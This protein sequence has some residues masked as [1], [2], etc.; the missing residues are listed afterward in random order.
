[1]RLEEAPLNHPEPSSC[2]SKHLLH[3]NVLESTPNL[4][5]L[6][7]CSPLTQLALWRPRGGAGYNQRHQS[8]HNLT[9]LL[10]TTH[11]ILLHYNET[12][13]THTPTGTHTSSGSIFLM[14]S[15]SK[16]SSTARHYDT[17]E[18]ASFKSSVCSLCLLVQHYVN[19]NV[20]V[21]NEASRNGFYLW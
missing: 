14:I 12:A 17:S 6:Q 20:R 8:I 16:I 21:D 7:G 5:R 19:R 13:C 1:M 2:L 3:Q 10:K 15:L 9:R 11:W 18:R 4:S